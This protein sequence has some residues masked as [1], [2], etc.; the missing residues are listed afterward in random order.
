MAV[1]PTGVI[2]CPYEV[3]SV[4]KYCWPDI[5]HVADSRSL[6]RLRRCYVW[7]KSYLDVIETFGQYADDVID[8]TVYYFEELPGNP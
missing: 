3:S 5:K 2:I 6:D 8:L 7:R 1:V 4:L